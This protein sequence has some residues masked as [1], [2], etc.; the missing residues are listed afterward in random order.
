M[1]IKSALK[2]G[3]SSLKVKP[4]R[5]FAVILLSVIAL[6]MFGLAHT[7]F[8]FNEAQ[9]AANNFYKNNI[10]TVIVTK[11][12]LSWNYYSQTNTKVGSYAFSEKDIRFF[13]NR[14]K[15]KNIPVTNGSV[16]LIENCGYTD[17]W[18]AYYLTNLNGFTYIPPDFASACGYAVESH[19]PQNSKEVA[20]SKYA[21][22]TFLY[23]NYREDIFSQTETIEKIEDLIGKNILVNGEKMQ[24]S[25]IVDT[26]FD[27]ERYKRL[28]EI[29]RYDIDELQ[30]EA[31]KSE[32]SNLLTASVHALC[33]VS[34][35]YMNEISNVDNYFEARRFSGAIMHFSEI[36]LYD[37]DNIGYIYKFKNDLQ[38]CLRE[39]QNTLG[40][41][42]CLLP[43][44]EYMSIVSKSGS[45]L[46]I[47]GLSNEI[48]QAINHAVD[49][50][51]SLSFSAAK[52]NDT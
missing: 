45:I 15:N 26:N 17:E 35:E 10:S 38:Y 41:N 52:V 48:N 29:N 3:V 28:K 23:A 31:L 22:E 2:A 6:S 13:N 25:G 12:K 4:L 9:S 7:I 42:Q 14:L 5:L 50:Y 30:L 1:P 36:N 24:I 39:G 19:L 43:I 37:R 40:N 27:S 34:N 20:L 44:G 16:N 47:S 8:S 21:A 11:N 32:L 33:F 49:N 51:V 46:Q 18:N